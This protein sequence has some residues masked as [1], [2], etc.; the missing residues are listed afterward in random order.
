MKPKNPWPDFLFALAVRFVCGVVMGG[1]ACIVLTGRGM[2]WAFSRNHTHA[3]LLWLVL[4]ALAGGLIAIVTLPRWQKP[5]YKRELD[6][7]GLLK[8][9]HTQPPERIKVGS[10]VVKKSTTIRT[11]DADG[12][13]HQY[14][15]IEQVPPEVRSELGALEKEAAQQKGSEISIEQIS[16]QGNTAT[17][18]IVQQNNIYVYK[19]VDESGAERT[20]HS[21]GEMPPEIRAAFE[22]AEKKNK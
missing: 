9:L 4:C 20:Y 12:K 7:L 13:E 15:S 22:E 1:V 3:P 2:L 18:K 19:V 5:W 17:S 8:G 6:E 21:L 14:S 11:T 10:T 16:Q